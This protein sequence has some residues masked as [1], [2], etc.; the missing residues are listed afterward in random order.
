MMCTSDLEWSH[1][2]PA[3]Q[4]IDVDISNALQMFTQCVNLSSHASHFV[5]S[6][7]IFKQLIYALMP[8]YCAQCIQL[9]SNFVT[10]TYRGHP[11]SSHLCIPM[12]NESL[13]YLTQPREAAGLVL[14]FRPLP[15]TREQ[16]RMLFDT[17]F[18]SHLLNSV[19][20]FFCQSPV[21]Q[22]TSTRTT[23]PWFV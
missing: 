15:S 8:T 19:V 17:E 18:T 13:P 6:N 23:C 3:H 10:Y 1:V 21:F 9:S 16:T 2:Q 12:G 7:E 4:V 14:I 20:E 11:F 5:C 22:G